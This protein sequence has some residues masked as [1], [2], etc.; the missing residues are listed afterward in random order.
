MKRIKRTMAKVLIPLACIMLIVMVASCG[1]NQQTAQPRHTTP[2]VNISIAAPEGLPELDEFYARIQIVEFFEEYTNTNIEFLWYGA[3]YWAQLPLMFASGNIPTVIVIN[4]R[5]ANFVSAINGGGFW[6]LTD[7]IDRYPNLGSMN[8]AV[9]SNAS[10][11]GRL[12][13]IPRS[14][15]LG[16][17]TFGIREDWLQNL[18]LNMPRT[19]DEF[20]EALW[21]FT[22]MDPD[23]NGLNDTYGL[24]ITS[25]AGPWDM[26]QMWFGVPN[27][28]GVLN[29]QLLPA[30]MH[31]EYDVALNW[32][33]RVVADGLINPGWWEMPSGEW[34]ALLRSTAG[35]TGDVFE[36]IR[37]AHEYNLNELGIADTWTYLRY[38][39]T[40]YGIRV[41]PTAGFNDVIAISRSGAPTEDIML[42]TLG[43]LNATADLPI[44]QLFELGI[45]G[46]DWIID[47]EGF[48]YQY[49]AAEREAMG[50]DP[51]T[52]R[53][54]LNQFTP[55]FTSPANAALRPPFRPPINEIRRFAAEMQ[56]WNEDY[57][58]ANPGASF[59][60]PTQA[61]HGGELN[62]VINTMRIDFIR[63]V[64]DTTGLHAQKEHW[65][66]IGGQDV[67]NE[68]N[69]LWRAS[70]R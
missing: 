41:L 35:A 2:R 11:N 19:L 12:Y 65:L 47:D 69:E 32:F 16:R 24:G 57:V 62:A 21:A 10:L 66:R 61:E 25:F 45:E 28:W 48:V 38:I 23:G 27:G 70:Q 55:F 54:G 68:V 30:H 14:R 60:S 3:G 39:D 67:I 51:R 44:W 4:P 43:V 18:G 46:R 1:G 33:R 7:Y 52:Y 8:P 31:P 5:D 37:N 34:D 59:L 64:I 13:G 63:G 22:W 20:Y 49:S 29:G 58:V 36:R 6:D 17:N 40:G 15:A 9:R 26:M 50:V 53:T 56:T 42:H